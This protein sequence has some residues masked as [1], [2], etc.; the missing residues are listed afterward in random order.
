MKEKQIETNLSASPTG[1]FISEANLNSILSSLTE[2]LRALSHPEQDVTSRL[3]LLD[4]ACDLLT[5]LQAT[6]KLCW[7]VDQAKAIIL[8]LFRLDYSLANAPTGKLKTRSFYVI[9]VFMG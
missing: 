7:Q 4:N 1:N 2:N 5:S 8:G 3:N 9:L 6:N